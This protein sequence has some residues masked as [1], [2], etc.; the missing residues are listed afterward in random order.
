MFYYIAR[1]KRK[2][3]DMCL[4]LAKMILTFVLM[5]ILAI[6]VIATANFAEAD[7][8]G[9][10]KVIPPTGKEPP[11]AVP[12]EEKE[13]DTKRIIAD[14]I[15]PK[16]IS[17]FL[18][19]GCSV[20]HLLKDATALECPTSVVP[21]LKNVRE[22]KL[23][24]IHDLDADIQ[25]KANDVWNGDP[26]YQGTGIV[27]A[28][29]D[30]G[31]DKKHIELQDSIIK[32][33]S[34]KGSPKDDSGHGTH[35]SGIITG[36][37]VY[38]ISNNYGYPSP[39]RATGVAPDAG[40]IVGKVCA[41]MGCFTS[42]IAAGIEWAVAE[43]ADVLSISIGGDPIGGVNCD[44]NYLADKANWA[45]DNG[46]VVVV[47]SGN[48]ES[49]T[50]VSSPACGSK[51]IAVGA[52]DQSDNVA[53]FS[54]SGP[55]LDLVA[56][57][58]NVLSTYSCDAAGDCGFYWYTWKSGT[59]MAAPHVAGAAAL[60]L[61]SHPGY[62]V[63]DVKEALYSTALDVGTRD[64]NG[65]VDAFAAVNFVSGPDNELPVITPIP[66]SDPFT[67]T[68]T[69]EYI[70][71]CTVTDNDPDY[72][73]NCYVSSGGIDTTILGIQNVTYSADPDA[74]GNIPTPEV[75][76]T[77]IVK[78]PTLESI[79]IS[80]ESPSI[81]EGS[82]Q[83]FTATGNYDDGTDQVLTDVTWSSSLTSVATIDVD[84]GLALG[85]SVGS[86]T[87]TAISGVKE[88]MTILEVTPA[89][90]DPTKTSVSS[91]TY[92]TE[93]GRFQDKHLLITIELLDDLGNLVSGASVSIDLYREG[94][95]IASGTSTTGSDGTVTFSLKNAA[96]GF[97]TTDVIGVTYS[98]LV[99]IDDYPFPDD[100]FDK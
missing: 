29:L 71:Y 58:V 23:L 12:S 48:D 33:K 69:D 7:Q 55:A 15:S 11:K 34:F 70:E 86:S 39:N 59:S 63:D 78:P 18:Q 88:G 50:G 80:P 67:Q 56:P 5:G 83:Q 57:G 25:I 44:G 24:H 62:S 54:N 60:V 74:A 96:S 77:T 4:N 81:T 95:S 27:I 16:D 85:I 28:I 65:R 91:I 35:V 61:Q 22:D 36:N 45:V 2:L 26:S 72:N 100:G 21:T 87:I 49:S 64:G 94:S 53:D 76:S 32:T 68:G 43:G 9:K 66:I 31:V 75:V 46:V 14:S 84:N 41:R 98:D 20:K 93:G 3:L 42:D 92:A 8:N 1:L 99:F 52:V 82:T 90:D 47:S 51:V 10:I 30:S 6:A 19:Q 89:P 73:G 37:G 79:S 17:N 38:E 40:I 13:G 97:Y